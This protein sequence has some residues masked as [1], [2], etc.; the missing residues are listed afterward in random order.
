[1]SGGA[2]P[3]HRVL[4]YNAPTHTHH[5]AYHLVTGVDGR[6]GHIRYAACLLTAHRIRPTPKTGD[7]IRSLFGTN[8]VI[9]TLNG[10]LVESTGR[11]DP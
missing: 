11:K 8:A 9:S 1:M 10:G 4:P 2:R 6:V 3:A 7:M 5:V